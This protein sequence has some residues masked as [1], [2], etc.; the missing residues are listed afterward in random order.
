MGVI[1]TKDGFINIAVGGDGQWRNLCGAIGRPELTE[2][3]AYATVRKRLENRP[4]IW[5]ILQ[6]IFA[7]KS[8]A[9]WLDLLE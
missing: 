3:P 9:E 7:E 5:A 4:E 2:D 6:P 1:E 8:S